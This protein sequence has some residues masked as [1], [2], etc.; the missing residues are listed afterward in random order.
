MI[1]E[2]PY[3]GSPYDYSGFL[4]RAGSLRLNGLLR[5]LIWNYCQYHLTKDTKIITVCIALTTADTQNQRFVT[6][7]NFQHIV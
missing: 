5:Q 4:Q 3:I 1:M 6:N 7:S 2:T